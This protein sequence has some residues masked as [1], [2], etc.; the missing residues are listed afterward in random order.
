MWSGLNKKLHHSYRRY[1]MQKS[2]LNKFIQKYNLG[3]NVNSVKW[4]YADNKLKTSFVTPDKSLL[5]TVVADNV[6]FEDAD[7]GVY[8]TDQLQKLL[9]VLDDDI[10]LSLT[11]GGDRV[12]SLKVKNGSVSI[13]YVLSD[14]SVIADPPKLKR[15]PDFQTKVKLDS[16]FIDTFIKGKGALADVDMFTFV[17]DAD[18]NLSAVIGYSSN[19]NT[20][21]VNIPVE[22]TVNGLTEPVTFNANLFK[23]MLVANKECKSA[24]LEV[25]NEGLAKVNFKIDDYDSTYYIV[26]MSDVD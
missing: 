12:T 7:L 2:K 9:A 16:K 6:K 4:T 11:K 21:R 8:Q 24:V 22:T 17:N 1:K 19:T 20:N 15:L 5:G 3:G 10:N 26:A 18:G 25:S 23:E 14:L 13:D